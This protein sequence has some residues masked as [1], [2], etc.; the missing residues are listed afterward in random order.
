MRNRR[1]TR[2]NAQLDCVPLAP[3]AKSSLLP[4]IGPFDARSK[5][6]GATLTIA[7]RRERPID[8]AA[9]V[10]AKE[11]SHLLLLRR[12][13]SV[14]VVAAVKKKKKKDRR[15]SRGALAEEESVQ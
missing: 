10:S 11:R 9:L 14:V 7:T 5:A 1:Q 15:S 4:G 2:Q 12:Y 8:R 13:R 3:A 6:D